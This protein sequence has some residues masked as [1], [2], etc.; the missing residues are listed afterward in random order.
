MNQINNDRGNFKLSDPVHFL[1]LGFGSGLLTPAPGTWGTLASVPLFLG[2]VVIAPVG[3]IAYFVVLLLSFLVGV[4]L[5]G[6]TAS[7]VG[8]PDHSAIVWDEFVG[9]WITM[10]LVIP[11]WPNIVLGF[12]LFRLFDILKP[13][14]IKV[15]DKSVHGGF[16][17][18]IDDVLAGVFAAGLLY[19]AQPYLSA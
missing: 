8:V 3:S 13:W 7:D 17:I 11:S 4:Y 12:I 1:A 9:F 19:L 14:P 10:A 6:K 16:G 2:L 15:L 5:C 18:M